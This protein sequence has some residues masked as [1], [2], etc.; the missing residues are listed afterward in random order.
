MSQEDLHQRI[1]ASLHES[2]L[3]DSH[4]PE[5]S[6]LIDE[7]CAVKGSALAAAVEGGPQNRAKVLFVW[8]CSEGQRQTELECLYFERYF[9]LDERIARG[10]RLPDSQL[11][12]VSSFYSLEEMKTSLVYNEALPLY[13][14]Q[15]GLC[16][17]FDGPG[18]LHI[19]WSVEDPVNGGSWSSAQVETINGLLPH[20][21]QFVCMRQALVDANALGSSLAMLLDNTRMGVVQLNPSGR[22]AEANDHARELLRKGDGLVDRGGLLHASSPVDDV[23]LQKLLA[24]ALPSVSHRGASGSIAVRRSLLL[25][26]LVLHISPTVEG[27][28]NTLPGAV[29]ALVLVVDPT[30]RLAIEP[31]L[32]AAALDLTPAESY[33]AAS[34]A[35]GN[36]IR[37]IAIATGRTE[38]T[39]RWHVKRILD[40]HDISRQ[41][42]LVQLVLPLAAL[43][44]DRP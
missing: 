40:K 20:L 34:L 9:P 38:N 1:L 6:V 22:I 4:W 11:V 24:R 37:D 41:M 18:G 19:G 29:A 44:K 27:Q 35:E 17:R 28:A 10:L 23:G 42:E 13:N 36:T 32:V 26:R 5:T 14:A 16:A 21:R 7:A 3:D 33:V 8:I 39:I 31:S 43:P 12:H 15:N 25:P 30:S 2:V